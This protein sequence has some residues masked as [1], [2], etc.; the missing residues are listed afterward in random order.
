M[1]NNVMSVFLDNT[2]DLIKNK[3][4]DAGFDPSTT[5]FNVWGFN[6]D[7]ELVVHVDGLKRV[8][9]CDDLVWVTGEACAVLGL[10]T[11]YWWVP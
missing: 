4:Y 10:P 6:D 8:S 5:T 3:S 9:W 1:L 2:L 11:E 7:G